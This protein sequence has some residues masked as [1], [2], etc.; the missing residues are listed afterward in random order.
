MSRARSSE[1]KRV[2]WPLRPI[3]GESLMGF[4]GRVAAHNVYD[5]TMAITRQAGQEFGHRPSLVYSPDADL[6]TLATALKVDVAELHART[7]QPIDDTTSNFFGLRLP[8]YQIE[9]MTRRFA[10]GALGRSAHHRAAWQFR[11]IPFCAGTWEYLTN[12]CGACNQVQ[13]WHHARGPER[14]DFCGT[15]L[16]QTSVDVVPVDWRPVLSFVAGLASPCTNER[17]AALARAPEALAGLEAEQLLELILHLGHLTAEHDYKG[18]ADKAWRDSPR[19]QAL[20]LK[21][22]AELALGWPD[23]LFNL[24]NRE[25]RGRT[26]GGESTWVRR[27][28]KLVRPRYLAPLSPAVRRV[29]GVLRD[30]LAS[31]SEIV[32][33]GR[34]MTEV[35]SAQLCGLPR[36]AL[37]EYRRE[38]RLK[39]IAYASYLGRVREGF[40]AEEIRW[41]A[42]ALKTRRSIS[43]VASQFGI[44]VH[45]V[46]QL[47]CLGLLRPIEH[48]VFKVRYDRPQ[49]EPADVDRLAARIEEAAIASIEGVPLRAA[50]RRLPGQKP[51]GPIINAMVYGHLPFALAPGEALISAARIPTSA[52]AKLETIRF[53]QTAFASFDFDAHMSKRDALDA[54]NLMPSRAEFLAPGSIQPEGRLDHR[55]VATTFVNDMARQF[56]SISELMARSGLTAAKVRKLL[57]AGKLGDETDFGWPRDPAEALV[58]GRCPA[59]AL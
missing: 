35:T 11:P 47:I 57:A 38:G 56:I 26:G 42:G 18:L 33:D 25:A 34:A 39:S 12:R 28:G 22:A 23:T 17:A 50:V 31:A 59:I 46:E 44:S 19:E 45:G 1:I 48:P 43:S 2:M 10:P 9:I 27:L 15:A 51:W 29:I 7:H 16:A 32:G 13:R 53:D 3:P 37:A 55:V 24:M 40:D 21:S 14:C 52:A 36:G 20:M 5:D 8:F 4:V 30:H 49:I 6:K 54:L 41:L 58:L